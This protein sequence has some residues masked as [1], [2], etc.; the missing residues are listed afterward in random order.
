MALLLGSFGNYVEAD[1]IASGYTTDA[2]HSTVGTTIDAVLMSYVEAEVTAQSSF[3]TTV[4]A[5]VSG[6]GPLEGSLSLTTQFTQ[7]T[8]PSVNITLGDGYTWD[9]T[10]TWDDTDQWQGTWTISS[11]FS[12]S[13]SGGIVHTPSLTID[14]A[15]GWVAS[16]HGALDGDIDCINNTSMSTIASVQHEG[17]VSADVL[18][19]SAIESSVDV[20]TGI[21][22]AV[23]TTSLIVPSLEV[24][25]EL[26]INQVFTQSIVGG[27]LLL[28][29]LT[30]GSDTTYGCTINGAITTDFN[31]V[32]D[33]T[34][35]T[36]PVLEIH[37]DLPIGLLT[38]WSAMGSPFLSA[39]VDSNIITSSSVTANN[40]VN[41]Q[42]STDSQ[43]TY[44]CTIGGQ[45][46]TDTIFNVTTSQTTDSVNS[47]RANAILDVEA[48]TV[49]DSTMITGTHLPAMNVVAVASIA[50][51]IIYDTTASMSA[52]TSLSVSAGI[53]Q[54]GSVNLTSQ[55]T[56]VTSAKSFVLTTSTVRVIYIRSE[57]RVVD[58]MFEN[59]LI[60]L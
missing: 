15:L 28:S 13:N 12:S 4:V 20:N 37:A 45:L 6:S 53:V 38:N 18:F 33:T 57:D 31:L 24:T 14:S 30:L 50:P 27:N 58:V 5:D 2:I 8:S 10:T 59:R 29:T 56:Q 44:S 48:S 25:S 16:I 35:T 22:L 54:N 32:L 39:S 23:N 1:Y 40:Q 17:T 36:N 51:S 41:A 46:T 49:I 9:D 47:I 60:E 34:Q 19:S 42:L 3:T 55:F 52:T 21:N 43:T 26:D 11:S 7:S